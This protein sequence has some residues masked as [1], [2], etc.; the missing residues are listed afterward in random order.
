MKVPVL[1]PDGLY[2][3]TWVLKT[4]KDGRVYTEHRVDKV[5]SLRVTKV[6]GGEAEVIFLESRDV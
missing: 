1:A 3:E 5:T 2:V 4:G 6:S